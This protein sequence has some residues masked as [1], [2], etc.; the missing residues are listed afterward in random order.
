MTKS[1]ASVRVSHLNVDDLFFNEFFPEN[2]ERLLQCIQNFEPAATTILAWRQP[3]RG[4]IGPVESLTAGPCATE[5]EALAAAILE[6]DA[7][8]REAAPRG[9]SS[10]WPPHDGVIG[11]F[12]IRSSTAPSGAGA[13]FT[14]FALDLGN[15]HAARLAIC[16][17]SPAA[18]ASSVMGQHL[19]PL[20]PNLRR[21]FRSLLDYRALQET[22]DNAA[23]LADLA[24]DPTAVVD[25]EGR[26]VFAN[27]KGRTL[28][29]AGTLASLDRDRR[30]ALSPGEQTAALRRI[31]STIGEK[32][33]TGPAALQLSNVNDAAQHW[34]VVSAAA[35]GRLAL[36][37]KSVDTGR[38]VPAP[39]LMRAF[40]L[41]KTEAQIVAALVAGQT[42]KDYA[43]AVS[44]KETTVRW[45]FGN[46]SEKMGCHSQTDVV[47]LVL[48]LLAS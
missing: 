19:A 32:P 15:D 12:C 38:Q 36:T 48:R 47:R 22:C 40:D 27:S 14:V 42:I 9:A 4:K 33:A 18:A 2:W 11:P 21:A 41:T 13:T 24:A 10:A 26:L 46:A 35:D 20:L 1:G 8:S 16:L 17:P 5:I 28:L 30:V 45:H 43:E 6:G 23:A 7:A 31:L 34:L 25:A 37:F 3:P 29:D 39:V 44:R